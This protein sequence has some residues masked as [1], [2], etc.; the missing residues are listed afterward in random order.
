VSVTYRLTDRGKGLQPAMDA[1]R[2]W[3]GAPTDEAGNP[4]PYAAEN[5]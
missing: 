5:H 4:L 1:L 2:V 3:A